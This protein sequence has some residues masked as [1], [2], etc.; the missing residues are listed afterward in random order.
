MGFDCWSMWKEIL[1]PSNVLQ[2]AAFCLRIYLLHSC[3]ELAQKRK[4]TKYSSARLQWSFWSTCVLQTNN[5]ICPM[6]LPHKYDWN[7]IFIYFSFT[8]TFVLCVLFIG[9]K[10]HMT[11]FHFKVNFEHDIFT[12]VKFGCFFFFLLHCKSHT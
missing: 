10:V 4:E 2:V 1:I 9:R 8:C 12:A 3:M 6:S 7:S 5:V 11:D